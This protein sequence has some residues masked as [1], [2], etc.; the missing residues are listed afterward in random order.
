MFALPKTILVTALCAGTALA[1]SACGQRGGLY[2]PPD[3]QA[4]AARLTA[5]RAIA[6]QPAPPPAPAASAPS[7]PPPPPL[8]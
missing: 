7:P 6:A 8:P 4:E 1:L 5:A 2:L 3:L